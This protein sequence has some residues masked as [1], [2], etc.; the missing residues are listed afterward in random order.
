MWD[1]KSAADSPLVFYLL[2]DDRYLSALNMLVEF[3]TIPLEER[4][5]MIV[6]VNGPPRHTR[7]LWGSKDSP[8]CTQTRPIGMEMSLILQ[9]DVFEGILPPMLLIKE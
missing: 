8:G 6:C 4:P 1:D 2:I 5:D 9:R 7:V 3:S